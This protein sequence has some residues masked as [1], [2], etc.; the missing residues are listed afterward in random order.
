MTNLNEIFGERKTK[1][2]SQLTKL[3]GLNFEQRSSVIN[4]SSFQSTHVAEPD[5][6]TEVLK[7][8]MSMDVNTYSSPVKEQTK[9]PRYRPLKV[10]KKRVNIENIKIASADLSLKI[11]IQ[12]VSLDELCSIIER[13]CSPDNTISI[14]TLKNLL[15]QA[16]FDLQCSETCES[17]ARYLIEDNNDHK[18]NYDPKLSSPFVIVSAIVRRIFEYYTIPT[19]DEEVIIKNAVKHSLSECYHQLGYEMAGLKSRTGDFCNRQQLHAMLTANDVAVDNNHMNYVMKCLYE[20]THDVDK[21][22]FPKVFKVFEVGG[23]TEEQS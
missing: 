3:R 20:F 8:F 14:D 17:I 9:K 4:L 10:F 15:S 13:K 21:L 7:P 1:R 18:I 2:L 19:A 22:P 12:R 11:Q 6:K 5:S 23:P 16:P